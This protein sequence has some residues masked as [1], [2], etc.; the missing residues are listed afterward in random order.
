MVSILLNILATMLLMKE[1]DYRGVFIYTE[2][3]LANAHI[4]LQTKFM[5]P[6][7]IEV[8]VSNKA[9]SPT[10]FL[11]GKQKLH[12]IEQAEKTLNIAR[13]QF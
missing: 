5:L 13:E 1:P 6:T 3:F 10:L 12:H 9:L 11:K 4:S 7:S 2:N 8:F